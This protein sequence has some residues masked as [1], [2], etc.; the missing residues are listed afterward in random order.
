MVSFYLMAISL[1][2][3]SEEQS[4]LIE[5]AKKEGQVSYWTTGLTPSY[6]KAIEEGFK[7]K[8]GLK[9]FQVSHSRYQTT[10]IV[11]KVSQELKAGKL[12]VDIICGMFPLFFYQLLRAGEIMKYDSPEY[13]HFPE[14]KGGWA[15]PG[16]WVMSKANAAVV[17]WNPKHVK[18]NIVQY[19]DL[20]DPQ[21]KGKICCTDAKVS[22][23]YLIVYYGLRKKLGKDFF[24]KLAKQ[25][26]VFFARNTDVSNRVVTGEFPVAIMGSSR[27]AYVAAM[28][29][30][31]IKVNYSKEGE[32]ILANPFAILTKAPHPNASKLLIDYIHSLEG[33]KLMVELDGYHP[34]REDVP[35]PPKV[36]EYARPLSQINIIPVDWKSMS[37]EEMDAV[38]KEFA[39]IFKK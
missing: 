4:R 33:Q 32:V 16:Y 1:A 11:S 18:K 9:S 35:I 37:V 6:A 15:E 38:R 7:K 28:E 23:S 21:F 13:R 17:M 8:Y 20:L 10:T 39:E 25:D 31:D 22:D 12:T 24:M 29:G 26:V 27:T 3:G 2:F 36:L 30:A 34:G 14:I 5:G 19:T